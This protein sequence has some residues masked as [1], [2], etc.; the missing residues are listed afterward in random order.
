MVRILFGLVLAVEVFAVFF[1][2]VGGPLLSHIALTGITFLILCVCLIRR[3][4]IQFKF[5][6][7]H[8]FYFIFLALFLISFLW[9]LAPSYGLNEILLFANAGILLALLPA[10]SF[11]E[12]DINL[13]S[14]FLIALAVGTTLIGYFIY[15]GIAFPR[16]T[17]T[18]VD[19]KE[20]FRSTGNDYA[21][22]ILLI[23]PVAFWQ[24]LKRH[25]R[26]TTVVLAVLAAAI[27][28][29]GFLLS[30]SRAAW[31]SFI[32]IA[33]IFA[34]LFFIKRG[35]NIDA[36]AN[37]M[38]SRG[39]YNVDRSSPPTTVVILTKFAAVIILTTM[40]TGGLQ[41]VR[42]QKFETISIVKKLLFQADEGAASASN[43]L[44]FWRGAVQIIKDKPLF[45]GGV[46]SFRYLFPKY[47]KT[48]GIIED[49]PHNIFLK[50]GVENGLP[51]ALFFMAF[52]IAVAV[53]IFK[54]WS[55]NPFHPVLFL[56]LGALGALAHNLL[57]FNFVASNFALFIVF[58]GISLSF[59]PALSLRVKR[60]N[61][62]MPFVIFITLFAVSLALLAL[63]AHEG[64]YNADFKRGR[65]ALEQGNSDEAVKFLERARKLIFSRDLVTYL[66]DAYKLQGDKSKWAVEHEAGILFVSICRFWGNDE[67]LFDSLS[68]KK[69]ILSCM[70]DNVA[71]LDSVALY[72][73]ENF[74]RLGERILSGGFLVRQGMNAK[75][76]EKL[77]SRALELDPKNNLKYYYGLLSA[78]K[79]QGEPV[80]KIFKQEVLDLLAEY[81]IVLSN[82]QKL[83][84]LT[85]NPAYAVK[86]YDF[87]GMKKESE[88]LRQ[89]WLKEMI[90]FSV[91]YGTTI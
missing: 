73:A 1:N 48:F 26:I 54:F 52:L 45:G 49:H 15:T 88:N 75:V 33:L 91:K 79:K 67:F 87:F 17:A 72:N 8:A 31:F 51:V 66:A 80:D 35:K 10:I 89:I 22:F 77:F 82:N 76:S 16:F 24:A 70:D 83:T 34:V 64:Y 20:T 90:K 44:E 50:I 25:N 29:S 39:R 65:A 59:V 28:M 9:S 12:K 69:A 62:K 74:A 40:F 18:F 61:P 58:I 2:R 55:R 60:S 7:A 43:R 42:S 56:S 84:V 13:F 47:Q 57:D 19:L 71:E 53:A 27:L 4:E 30:F 5:S 38:S 32:G 14:V 21:N 41:A 63:S 3:K 23:L 85:E 36:V 86:L 11:S 6:A 37:P 81:K 46:R 68:I 78:Q